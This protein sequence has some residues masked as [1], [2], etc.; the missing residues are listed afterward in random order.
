MISSFIYHQEEACATATRGHD[1]ELML[2]WTYQNRRHASAV[3][4]SCVESR[5]MVKP[6][7]TTGDAARCP[8]CGYVLLGLPELRCP[9]CGTS[10]DT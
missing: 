10:F 4:A 2:P 9:E 7:D 6:A 3:I 5:T 8:K 1:V